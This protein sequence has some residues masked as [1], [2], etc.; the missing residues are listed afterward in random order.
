MSERVTQVPLLDLR[1]H[2]ADVDAELEEA[3][4]RVLRSG[5]Y[6]LGPEVD[7]L[8]QECAAHLD[9]RHALGASSGTDALILALMTLGIGPGDEVICPTYTFFATA[10]AVW[11]V[12]AR[13]VFVESDPSTFNCDPADVARKITSKTKAVI[14]VHLFGQAAEMGPIMDAARAR[15]VTVIE[16]A[17]QAFGAG[18][19][20]RPVGTL[21]AFG[22]FSFFPSKNLG[23]FGDGGLVT[24]QDDALA[25]R[26]RIMRAHGGKPKYHH[27][28][29]GGNFRIDPLQAALVRVKLAR[30]DGYT[31]ARQR[32]ARLY[33]RLLQASGCAL[34]NRPEAPL[35]PTKVLTP[36]VFQSRHIYNQ[37]VVRVPGEGRRDALIAHLKDRKIGS[38]VY[39]PV[40]MHLQQCFS[41]LGHRVGDFPGAEAAA[42]ET[43][44]LPIFPELSEEEITYVAEAV[45]DFC[46]R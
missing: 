43:L 23:G 2:G 19:A 4:R 10:G 15:G 35:D 13:P 16:D 44:A 40:P 41:S 7:A 46:R 5:H 34:E 3:F 25:E 6:I 38:E 20:G 45:V 8:E 36:V 31:A 1:R 26:A 27:Q 17:A 22:C 29:V 37:Y 9:A 39:Y 32:N 28:F 14:P 33:D 24:T 18:Y 12:G 42:R 30:L 11:R 21:G